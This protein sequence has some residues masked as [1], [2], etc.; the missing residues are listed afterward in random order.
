MKFFLFFGILLILLPRIVSAQTEFS[1]GVSPSVIDLGTLNEG[2]TNIVK[3]FLVTPSAEPL[4]V[5]LQPES[6]NIDFFS[7]R[8]QGL[9]VNYSEEDTTS[10]LDLLKNP[11]ELSPSN[12]TLQTTAGQINGWT[13]INFLINVPANAEPGY[14]IVKIKPVPSVPSEVLSGAGAR[15]VAVTYVTALF[16]VPGDPV[17]QGI[18][19]DVNS[20]NFVGNELEIRTYFQNTGTD[21]ISARAFQTVYDNNGTGIANLTS[22][23]DFVKPGETEVLLSYLP[24]TGLAIGDY[25][26]TTNVGYTTGNVSQN[27]TITLSAKPPT[28]VAAQPEAFPSWILILVLIIIIIVT[29]LIYKWSK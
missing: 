15:V 22:A 9:I 16:N 1:V 14:H 10:W 20:G 7:T 5:N 26:I 2:S 17:R 19:L 8:Y 11:V 13:E 12:Q 25:N 27:S 18:I 3:F 6:G 4:L 21:T 23:N 28:T 24:T 29:I